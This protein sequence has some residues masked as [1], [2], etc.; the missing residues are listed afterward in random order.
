MSFVSE[1]EKH[2]KAKDTSIQ[3]VM[4][5]IKD[6]SVFDLGA[7]PKRIY[8]RKE[9]FKVA[10]LMA[11]YHAI[12]IPNNII[13]YGPR[14]SGKTISILYFL[15]ILKKYDIKTFY[16]NARDC[17]MSY[18]IY[19]RMTNTLKS[20][21]HP[22]VLREQAQNEFKEKSVIVIDDAD[23]LEDFEILYHFSRN[24]KA[25]IILLA[26]NI[27]FGK[28]IDDA[29]Y[30]S[31]LPSKIF[32]SEYDAEALYQILKMRAEVGLYKWNDTALRLIAAIVSRDY[33]GDA[34]IAIRALFRGALMDVWDQEE[35]I[36]NAVIEAARDIAVTI[37]KIPLASKI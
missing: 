29:T 18:S 11:E 15:D 16:V 3:R 2:F 20:G 14:G 28:R 1:L 31:L 24:T 6:P 33:H 9:L 30:S 19:Q 32:F 10:D 8:E 5:K 36:E 27:Q 12:G 22:I 17:P 13:I 34:R 7:T 23:F 25:S 26:Q 35:K 4:E 21:Y 37:R